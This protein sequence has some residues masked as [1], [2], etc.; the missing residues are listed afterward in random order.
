MSNSR[1]LVAALALVASSACTSPLDL[2]DPRVIAVELRGTWSRV[3]D[4]PGISTVLQLSVHDSTITG[5]GTFSAEAGPSG[6]LT[7][8]GR[9]AT[10][11]PAGTLVEIDFAQSDGFVGHFTGTLLSAD[12]LYGSVW[13]TSANLT[14]DP[15]PATFRRTFP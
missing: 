12:S 14:A 11:Q 2:S 13:Y 3:F 5:T 15:V 9:I 6:T 1:Q 7:V 4:A 8:T 10:G